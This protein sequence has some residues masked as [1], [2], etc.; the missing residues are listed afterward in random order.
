MNKKLTKFLAIQNV[1]IILLSAIIG[2]FSFSVTE[3]IAK[4]DEFDFKNLISSAP[5]LPKSAKTVIADASLIA[6]GEREK[7]EKE[8]KLAVS[9]VFTKYNK[10]YGLN[11]NIN[12]DNLSESLTLVADPDNRKV[13]ELYVSECFQSIKPILLLHL[14]QKLVL[15]CDY[16]LKPE[17]LSSNQFSLPDLFLV[18]EK[19]EQLVL[20]L[21]DI[22][23][24][25]TV[26]DSDKILQKLSEEKNDASLSS[27]ESK[28]AVEEFMKLFNKDQNNKE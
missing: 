6:K 8:M 24:N 13:L 14:M 25:T 12:L 1:I 10:E 15:L 7:A 22:I 26:K 23:E 17:N 20:N 21:S 5:V 9:E 19:I 28:A 4:K 2:L 18:V 11:L 3:S 16:I 27:P